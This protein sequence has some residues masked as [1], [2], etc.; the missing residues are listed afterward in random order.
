MSLYST[1]SDDFY[2]N[3]N[4]NTEMALPVGRE[5]TLSFFE[6]VRK[7]YSTMRNFYTRDNGDHVLEEDKDQGHQRWLTLEPRR[8][9]SGY[10]NPDDV[11]DA[12]EQHKLVLELVP[13]MLSVS[14]LDCEALDYMMGF[15]FNYRG[16]HDELVADALGVS[17]ALDGLL[18]I[19][20]RQVLN[21]EPTMTIALEETCRRQAR[22]L[23]ET[24]TNAYQVRRSDYPEEHISVFFTV[25]QYGSLESDT[26]YEE[27]LAEL[28]AQCESLLEKYVIDQVLR[29]LQQ[30]IS[31]K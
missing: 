18:E 8:I 21:F 5:T 3:M 22:L 17:S 30:A 13:Y 15:D 29:P 23:I 31:A 12:F 10:I 1:L 24:R 27:T 7:Q 2:V 26:S 9:C 14:S 20:G 19:P 28:K 6:R 4:L 11:D 25:R 16:N